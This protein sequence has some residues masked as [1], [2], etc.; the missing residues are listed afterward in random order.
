MCP[1]LHAD[2]HEFV[3]M[4]NQMSLTGRRID[5]FAGCLVPISREEEN[6]HR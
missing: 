6:A 2:E 5:Y 3:C 1:I 4:L